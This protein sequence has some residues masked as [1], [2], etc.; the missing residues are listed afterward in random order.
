MIATNIVNSTVGNM[1][2]VATNGAAPETAGFDFMNYLLGLQTSPLD[3]GDTD[4]NGPA[5]VKDLDALL[6]GALAKTDA[7][8]GK[9]SKQKLEPWNLIFPGMVPGTL[10]VEPNNVA[11]QST[12]QPSEALLAQAIVPNAVIPDP[13][14]ATS[15]GIVR[16]DA[17]HPDLR[18]A[19]V[20]QVETFGLPLAAAHGDPKFVATS[21]QLQSQSMLTDGAQAPASQQAAAQRYAQVACGESE[22]G[23]AMH[24]IG[25]EAPA[26]IADSG[27]RKPELRDTA[28]VDPTIASLPHAGNTHAAGKASLGNE[29]VIPSSPQTVPQ[30]HA[31]VQTLAQ[32]GGGKMTVALSPPELGKV[33]VQVTTRGK[34]VEL[35]MTSDSSLAK[36][37][38]ESG[39]GELRKQLEG[40]NLQLAHTEVQVSHEHFSSGGQHQSSSQFFS[41]HQ[42][43]SHSPRD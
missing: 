27:G 16:I 25:A 30:L 11:S 20:L 6:K 32:A 18:G 19:R 26:E 35:K 28:N 22:P 8:A 38:L 34:R 29:A 31:R 24:P 10:S 2:N 13:N 42:N 23:A 17:N 39:L 37:V 5:N 3:F 9:S 36:S 33:E 15:A 43:G 21:A 12:G 40:Q 14:A 1:P 7:E 4:G 41:Q